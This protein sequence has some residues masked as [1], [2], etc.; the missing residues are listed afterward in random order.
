MYKLAPPVAIACAG[1]FVLAPDPTL[2]HAQGQASAI[3]G[4][5]TLNRDLSDTGADRIQGRGDARGGGFPRGGG[6]GRGGGRGGFGGGFPGGGGF[7]GGPNGRDPQDAMRRTAALGDILNA[8]ERLTITQTES[9]VIITAGDGRATRLS[10]DGKKIKDESTNMER[11]TKWES[12]KLISEITGS[13]PKIIETYSADSDHHELLVIV[14]VEGRDEATRVFHRLY[15][16][17][18]R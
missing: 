14:Q 18:P 11:K 7:G 8:P 10:L 12:G 4:A 15:E 1:F 13:G 17:I 6:G 2:V 3:V 9:M 5:W 16:A